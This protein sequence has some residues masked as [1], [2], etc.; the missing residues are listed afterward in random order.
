MHATRR[1]NDSS[2][3]RNGIALLK[4]WVY[5]DLHIAIILTILKIINVSKNVH[6][7]YTLYN[8]ND[9]RYFD[10]RVNFIIQDTARILEVTKSSVILQEFDQSIE[11]LNSYLG[12]MATLDRAMKQIMDGRRLRKTITIDEESAD[13]AFAD[14]RVGIV[15]QL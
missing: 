15:V 6:I 14:K 2:Q 12:E 1:G 10:R 5:R 8:M 9:I 4:E 13:K 7:V 11:L 3:C